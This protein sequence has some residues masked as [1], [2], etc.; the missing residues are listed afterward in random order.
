MIHVNDNFPS[1]FPSFPPCPGRLCVG[2]SLLLND[3]H[4]RRKFPGRIH[5]QW[6]Y[7]FLLP[8]DNFF[9]RFLFFR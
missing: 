2:I 4:P 9:M 6:Y 3:S 5:K 7:E 8:G 1:P